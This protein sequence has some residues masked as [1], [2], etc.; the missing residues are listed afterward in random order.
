M[1]SRAKVGKYSCITLGV[2]LFCFVGA[3]TALESWK[4]IHHDNPPPFSSISLIEFESERLLQLKE[5]Q[6]SQVSQ[7]FNNRCK[8]DTAFTSFDD[9]DDF[10]KNN[11]DNFVLENDSFNSNQVFED[12]LHSHTIEIK[13][14][15]LTRCSRM[16]IKK[17]LLTGLSKSEGDCSSHLPRRTGEGELEAMKLNFPL[18]VKFRTYYN[19]SWMLEDDN[20]G[21]GFLQIPIS[22]AAIDNELLSQDSSV[23]ISTLH[24]KE[25]LEDEDTIF[26]TRPNGMFESFIAL[27]ILLFLH[28]RIIIL[29]FSDFFFR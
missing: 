2:F 25:M 9:N 14:H 27:S 3:D 11:Q 10:L 5:F 20:D 23:L 29:F 17:G 26:E 1:I 7:P 19:L 16:G 18:P 28:L 12:V 15:I 13:T 21:V 6:P 22:T 4:N 24:S 8:D